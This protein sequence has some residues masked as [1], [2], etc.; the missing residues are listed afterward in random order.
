[1]LFYIK[2]QFLNKIKKIT[3][4]VTLVVKLTRVGII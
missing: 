1:L 2:Q 4:E 3:E